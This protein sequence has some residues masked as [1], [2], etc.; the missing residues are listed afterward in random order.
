MTST[1]LIVEDNPDNRVLISDV[2]NTLDV[3]VLEATDGVEGVEMAAANLPDLVLMDLSLPLKDGWQ[4]TREIKANPKTQHIPVV[5]LT[6]H[7]MIGDRERALAVG[8]AD[9]ISKP[10]NMLELIRKIEGYLQSS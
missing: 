1:I 7:A 5:A 8:C 2:L 3:T 9:Y 10:I 6:A 4:A